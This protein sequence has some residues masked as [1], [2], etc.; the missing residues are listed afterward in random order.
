MWCLLF[1]SQV[2]LAA[3][4]LGL[5]GLKDVVEMVLT[6]DYC[7]FFPKV[8]Y[9]QAEYFDGWLSWTWMKMSLKPACRWSLIFQIRW[10][11]DHTAK[12]SFS[13]HTQSSHSHV[14]SM[15]SEKSLVLMQDVSF[16]NV[17][18]SMWHHGFKKKKKV[19][20]VSTHLALRVLRKSLQKGNHL[21][22]SLV[23]QYWMLLH[24][25]WNGLKAFYIF[26]L[27]FGFFSCLCAVAASWW[28]SENSPWVP[29]FHTCLR[30]SK[31]PYAV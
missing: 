21:L 27:L 7:R 30:S 17:H 28:S 22:F 2:V 19:F 4:M 31:P 16:F 26:V 23:S 10:I 8:S 9:W 13:L 18:N 11:Y 3:D 1:H 6:R 24:P 25:K 12:N 29:L 14:S 5:E 20:V 15:A